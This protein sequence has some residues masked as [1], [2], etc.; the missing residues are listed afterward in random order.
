MELHYV[1]EAIKEKK[2]FD[3]SARINDEK[4]AK[5]TAT[6]AISNLQEQLTSL[7]A[8]LANVSKG[9]ESFNQQLHN[10]LGRSDISLEYDTAAKG[11]KIIRTGTKRSASN[12]SEG[13]KTDIAFVYFITKLTEN[14]NKIEDSIVVID[15]PIS[16]FDSNHLFHS[17]AF[18]KAAC[19]KA[20]QIF[21][22]THNFQYFKLVRDWIMKKNG[23]KTDKTKSCAYTIETEKES[24]RRSIINNAHS[25]LLNHGSEYHYLFKKLHEFGEALNLDVEQAYQVANYG[26]KLLE[27]FFTFKHPKGRNDFYQ[28]MEA[29]C[30][31]AN[32]DTTTKEKIY[33][34]INKY[35]HLQMIDFHESPI[36]NLLGEGENITQLIFEIIEKS[37]KVHFDEMQDICNN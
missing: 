9:A 7:E 16:S 27:A 3:L 8:K 31:Q 34:F 4:E 14:G 32:I 36:D 26:R 1:A 17:M 5:D 11:Y 22:L 35:S 30:K 15:D 28:L 37:D 20:K 19:E 24:P 18:L 10:F 13:E 21:I 23:A 6:N 12:L 2:Y 25:S 33:R 29:G